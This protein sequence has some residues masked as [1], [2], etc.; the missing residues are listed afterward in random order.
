MESIP[1]FNGLQFK[2]AK[3]GKGMA[4]QFELRKDLL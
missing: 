1:K 2:A 4:W 3:M